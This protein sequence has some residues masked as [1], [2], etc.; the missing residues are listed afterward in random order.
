MYEEEETSL[1]LSLSLFFFPFVSMQGLP[2]WAWADI[3]AMVL[4]IK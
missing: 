4:E 2:E 1:S 3:P